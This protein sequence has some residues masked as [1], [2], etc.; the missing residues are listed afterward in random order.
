MNRIRP[1]VAFF[2]L[3]LA[4]VAFNPV[5]AAVA[6]DDPTN[7]I[8][9]IWRF[10]ES[11]GQEILETGNGWLDDVSLTEL[12]ERGVAGTPLAGG[13]GSINE[14]VSYW[15]D[16]LGG[17][18][19]ERTG[20]AACRFLVRDEAQL[21]ED[22]GV[23]AA[24]PGWVNGGIHQV[25]T[26]H[27]GTVQVSVEIHHTGNQ[28][29]AS[30]ERGAFSNPWTAWNEVPSVQSTIYLVGAPSTGFPGGF[31]QLYRGDQQGN[32]VV[33]SGVTSSVTIPAHAQLDRIELRHSNSSV[34]IDIWYPE[35]SPHR[36]EDT[37]WFDLPKRIRSILTCEDA[38]GNTSQAEIVNDYEW[39]GLGIITPIPKL[40]CPEG[41]TSSAYE[42]VLETVT[43][44]GVVSKTITG[45]QQ[46]GAKVREL[47]GLQKQGKQ[48]GLDLRKKLAD[49]SDISCF[50]N[51]TACKF[52]NKEPGYATTYDCYKD[53]VKISIHLCEAVGGLYED[54]DAKSTGVPG[55]DSNKPP[56]TLVTG[57]KGQIQQPGVVGKKPD[58][59]PLGS[60]STQSSSCF[61]TGWGALNPVEWIQKPVACAGEAL[62]IPEGD[63]VQGAID[64]VKGNLEGRFP[65]NLLTS[66]PSVISAG[67]DGFT[68][69]CGALPNFSGIDG[70]ELRMPCAPPPS[71]EYTVAYVLM[72]GF[73]WLSVAFAAYRLVATAVGSKA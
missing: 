69:N 70:L 37:S 17:S 29:S 60:A 33:F 4:V 42:A 50:D 55:A 59:P 31:P 65:T 11:I 49:G 43:S 35:D 5:Q 27:A 58:L 24:V 63:V 47:L 45:V 32:Y 26:S 68:G 44:N 13:I 34:L 41:Y 48:V 25:P 22:F 14:S 73:V 8:S 15:C 12:A 30:I 51:P 66:M 52:W 10:Y 53:G 28:V 46:V 18:V 21:E 72:T 23:E 3:G 62:F 71:T 1:L 6:A 67:F 56:T 40:V 16:G 9:E 61:P 38:N 57:D 64:D 54:P 39:H 19:L 36:P 2:M 20:A 7:P